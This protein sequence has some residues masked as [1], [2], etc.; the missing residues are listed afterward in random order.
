MNE[1][2]RISEDT[3]GGGGIRAKVTGRNAD[4]FIDWVEIMTRGPGHIPP[5]LDTCKLSGTQR[6]I[7]EILSVNIGR[8]VSTEAIV[9]H[10]YSGDPDGGP[11]SPRN[12]I[13]QH[14]FRANQR[15]RRKGYRI[16]ADGQGRRL[17]Y[18]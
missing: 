3:I 11:G 12:T 1:L 2:K 18:D 5:V 10:V 9:D 8:W 15:I 17:V 14:V 7:V 13:T 6:K 4:L 16:D